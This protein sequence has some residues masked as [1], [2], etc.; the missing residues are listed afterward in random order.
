VDRHD[1]GPYGAHDA[2]ECP[3]P[4]QKTLEL[5]RNSVTVNGRTLVFADGAAA[6]RLSIERIEQM[7]AEAAPKK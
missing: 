7:M 3:N 4:L 2:A 1:G 6:G 5:G